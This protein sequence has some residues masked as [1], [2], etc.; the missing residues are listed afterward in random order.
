[1]SKLARFELDAVVE[2]IIEQIKESKKDSP[3]QVEYQELVALSKVY[4]KELTQARKDLEVELLKKYKDTHPKLNFYVYDYDKSVR[5]KSISQPQ[6]HID[7][8][9]IERELIVSN[10][11][12]NVDETIQKI[13]EKYTK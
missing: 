1:M 10:I 13:V 3:E 12:G 2:T 11:K 5:I 9:T 7:T 6:H 4:E 8:K